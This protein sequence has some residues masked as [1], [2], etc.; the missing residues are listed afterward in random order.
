MRLWVAA[1][2]GWAA[3]EPAPPPV[4]APARS[5]EATAVTP[6]PPGGSAP[7]H[8]EGPAPSRAAPAVDPGQEPDRLGPPV[9]V[10]D[11]GLGFTL[12]EGTPRVVGPLRTEVVQRVV[13]LSYGRFRGCY[14]AGA[15]R[16]P[17][18]TGTV[19]L[20][21]WIDAHGAVT[22]LHDDGGTLPDAETVRC[23]LGEVQGLAFPQ[24][25]GAPVSVRLPL[26]FAP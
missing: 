14:A 17:S 12:R 1:V 13:R 7:L 11:E 9:T 6:L 3:C 22:K 18:L 24:P 23:V 8:G 19:V 25:H 10:S 4:R 5:A 20:A 15:Q 16:H 21:F 26:T 2:V